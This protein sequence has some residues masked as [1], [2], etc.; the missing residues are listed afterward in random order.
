MI[1][2]MTLAVMVLASSITQA[3]SGVAAESNLAAIELGCLIEPNLLVKLGSAVTGVLDSVSVDRGDVVHAGQ[4][5][6]RLD[7][8][9]E[10]AVVAL[11]RARAENDVA[12]Q[13]RSERLEF[14]ISKENRTK[15][16]FQKKIISNQQMEVAETERRLADLDLGEAEKN[17]EILQLE[18]KQA[19]AVLEQRRIIS[20]FDGIVVERVLSPGEYVTEQSHVFSVAKPTSLMSRS[21]FPSSFLAR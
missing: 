10:E 20:P 11:A 14:Q 5:I 18:L 12:I 9:V 8:G 2:R 4:V 1:G 15:A 7:S 17:K 19:I 21:S 16:L 3:S 13:S 6:A